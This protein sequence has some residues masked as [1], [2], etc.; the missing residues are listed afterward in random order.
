MHLVKSLCNINIFVVSAENSSW[1]NIVSVKTQ[2][3]SL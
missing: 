3:T 2:N 1:F